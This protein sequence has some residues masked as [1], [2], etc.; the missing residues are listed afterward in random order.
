MQGGAAGV[1]R[2]TNYRRWSNNAWSI[3]ETG[4]QNKAG[5]WTAEDR[6]RLKRLVKE[7]HDRKLWIRFYTLNG[8]AAELGEANGWG[9]SYNF[10][11]LE[12]ARERWRAA[13]QAGVDFV[14]TDQYAE[15]G[16]ELVRA[17]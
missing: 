9:R 16:Q 1:A 6:A 4:G 14:A 12:A 5:E 2:A 10:G 11:S 13:I 17:R 15:F 8:H 7:A 3:V